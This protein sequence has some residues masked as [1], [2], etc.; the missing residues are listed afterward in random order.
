M[1]ESSYHFPRAAV[2][3]D[4]AVNAYDRNEI[5]SADQLEPIYLRNQVVQRRSAS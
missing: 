4:L 3:A 1:Q 5:V 2:L